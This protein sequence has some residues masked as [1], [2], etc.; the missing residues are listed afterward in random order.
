MKCVVGVLLLP[1]NEVWGKVMF[2]HMSVILFTGVCVFQH[3]MDKGCVFQHAMG[4][5]VS[6]SGSGGVSLWVHGVCLWGQDVYTPWINPQEDTPGQTPPGHTHIPSRHPLCRHR[7]VE[8][9]IEAIGTHPTGMHSHYS[10]LL[11]LGMRNTS[12]VAMSIRF[13]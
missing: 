5:G 4:K 12:C 9:A 3:V 6:A 2:L 8:M 11:L 1:T 7:H 10:H 13:C